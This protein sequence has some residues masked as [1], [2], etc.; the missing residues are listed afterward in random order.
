MR[1]SVERR[2][3]SPTGSLLIAGSIEA[4]GAFAPTVYGPPPV[5]LHWNQLP[6]CWQRRLGFSYI[7]IY[8][9]LQRCADTRLAETEG[10]EW[11]EWR[12]GGALGKRQ[13][14]Y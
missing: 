2:R 13:C 3:I 7:Y 1:Q 14:V 5:T 4:A 8:I 10:V 6:G 9:S 11:G 12:G